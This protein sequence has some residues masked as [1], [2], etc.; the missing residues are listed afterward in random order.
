MKHLHQNRTI[1]LLLIL[2]LALLLPLLALARDSSRR[3]IED[4]TKLRS[5]PAASED[6]LDP[7]FV[8]PAVTHSGDVAAAAL[9]WAQTDILHGGVHDL[10]RGNLSL[11][12][13]EDE[14]QWLV[15]L[16]HSDG[17]EVLTLDPQGRLLG[18]S[19][20]EKP[21]AWYGGELP[22]G[23]DEAVLSYITHFARM[24]GCSSVTGYERLNA[25][26]SGKGYDVRVTAAALLDGTRCT[27]TISLETMAFTA[28]DCPLP[29]G[30]QLLPEAYRLAMTTPVP[31][32]YEIFRI[33]LGGQSISVRAT[34]R[35]TM[36]D[37]FSQWPGDALPREEV[38]SIA[39]QALMDEFGLTLEDVTAE[40]FLYG[41][42]AESATHRWQLS[43]A[44]QSNPT[45]GYEYSVY[46]RDS[47]GA[48]LGV[49][50]PEEANG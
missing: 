19:I 21:I 7:G 36:G 8:R 9:T 1:R 45:G 39:L 27:F 17:T 12:V 41:Y 23:T 40:P 14:G 26:W 37:S 24:N 22:A 3:W 20:P 10:Y 42:D 33:T 35:R 48:V 43:F 4:I 47:D 49:W 13:T 5:L 44:S 29:A 15:S 32:E 30:V 46:I 50:G 38:F 18:Y 28:V 11:F 31:A 6:R 25:Q 34:D 2:S 16:S